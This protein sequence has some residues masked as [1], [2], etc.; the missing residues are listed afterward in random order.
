MHYKII[1]EPEALDDLLNIKSYITKQDS[2]IKANNFIS[3]LKQVIKSLDSMAQT[4]R[5]SL[6][7]NSEDTHDIIHK[8]YTVVCKIINH[9]IHILTI[10]RQKSY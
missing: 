10:F 6:Y 3:E 2:M 1:V 4:C 9:N 8:G 7:S 5:K